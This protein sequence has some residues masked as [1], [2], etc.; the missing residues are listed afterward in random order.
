M[1]LLPGFQEDAHLLQEVVHQHLV[2]PQDLVGDIII[3]SARPVRGGSSYRWLL[4]SLLSQSHHHLLDKRSIGAVAL[5]HLDAG[6]HRPR[7]ERHEA[8]EAQ[9]REGAG[10]HEGGVRHGA[11]FWL[12]RLLTSPFL[13]TFSRLATTFASR[14]RAFSWR[15]RYGG[16][17][18][19][20]PRGSLLLRESLQLRLRLVLQRLLQEGE[21]HVPQVRGERCLQQLSLAQAPG[22]APES[23]SVGDDFLSSASHAAGLHASEDGSGGAVHEVNLQGPIEISAKIAEP[24]RPLLHAHQA[25]QV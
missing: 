8:V 24:R 16:L 11:L 21:E 18:L 17:L 15:L 14:G 22:Q 19:S 4:R 3:T 9:R 23:I 13:T 25:P 5:S 10:D 20:L 12:R 1:L 2:E 6:L 7:P